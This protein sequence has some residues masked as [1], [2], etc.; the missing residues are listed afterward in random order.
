MF[1]FQIEQKV[2]SIGNVR[3]GGQPGRRRT[4]MI[5]SL[6]Y[7]GHSIVLDRRGGVIDQVRLGEILEGFHGAIEETS[8]PAGIMVYAET[9]EAMRSHLEC[10]SDLTPSPLFI[11]SAS[12]E[13]RIE[14]ARAASEMGILDRTVYNSLGSGTT[15]EEL[16]DIQELGIRSA[17]LLAF[18]PRELG[19]KGKIYLLEN[20]HDILDEG[21]IDLASRYGI[22]MPLLD[23][24][25]MSMDQSAGSALR[26]MLVAKAKWGL[27]S[28]CALH[29]AV[30]SWD[31]PAGS[32]SISRTLFRNVDMASTIAPIMSGADFVMFG[33]LEAADRSLYA[34]AFTDELLHQ[35]SMDI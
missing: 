21:L 19:I 3:F 18:S 35:A 11:D 4:V 20:G 22:D 33:P 10:L 2:F 34:A 1:S 16:I 15:E 30:E 7:P 17:V 12:Q 31:P 5:G 24:A 29:N 28:G 26:A 23:M 27:P 25:V 13:V 9:G 8:T 32:K 6:F 14:G